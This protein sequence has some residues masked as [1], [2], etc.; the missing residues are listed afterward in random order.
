MWEIK[1]RV[2]QNFDIDVVVASK[3]MYDMVKSSPITGHLPNVH[4]IPFGIETDLFNYSINKEQVRERLQINNDDFV[5]LFRADPSPFKGLDI[6]KQMLDDLIP[7]KP[8]TLLTVGQEY[9]LTKYSDRYT[10][11]QFGWVTDD[12]LM[13]E[14][15]QACDVLIMPSKAESFGMMAVEAMASGKPVIVMEG[16]ALPGVTFA[17]ECGIVIPKQNPHQALKQ[18]VEKLMSDDHECII[19]GKKGREIVEKHYRFSTYVDKH[20]QLYREII[21]RKVRCRE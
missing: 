13:A 6:I 21:A 17:P 2:F 11:R 7:K 19:R 4:H 20:I 1:R 8:V 3:Y 10:I 16:S 15:Y 5:L 14:I 18:S 9:M 12:N